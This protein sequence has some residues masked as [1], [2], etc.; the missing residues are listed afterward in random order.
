MAVKIFTIT[1]VVILSWYP[2]FVLLEY[3]IPEHMIVVLKK[4]K[5]MCHIPLHLSKLVQEKYFNFPSITF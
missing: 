4:E 1:V 2:D 3:T 5:Q